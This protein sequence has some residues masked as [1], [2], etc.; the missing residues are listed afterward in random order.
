MVC[1]RKR[2]IVVDTLKFSVDAAL[3]RELGE[4]LIGQ[5]HIALA[6]LIKNSYDADAHTCRVTFS[7]DT[8]EIIDDGHGMSL[9]EFR[10]FWMRIGTTHKLDDRSSRD[11]HRPLTG[12][13]GVG[14]LAVQ[15]LARRMSLET[16]TGTQPATTLW[17]SVDWGTIQ[18]GAELSSV[19][20]EWEHRPDAPSYPN[21]SRHGTRI[22]LSNLSADW[23]DPKK[24][25]ALGG[26]LWTLRSPFRRTRPTGLSHDAQD[27]DVEV[28]SDDVR[29]AQSVFNASQEALFNNWRAR[30]RGELHNGRQGH[31]ATISVEFKTGY[32]EGADAEIFRTS[33]DFPITAD[34]SPLVDEVDFEILV[35]K[36]EG[37]QFGNIKVDEMRRYLSTFGNVSIYDSGFR[38]PYYGADQDWLSIAADQTARLSLSKLLPRSLHL[39]EERYMLDL[40]D[41]RRLY[42][43]VAISTPHERKVAE[44]RAAPNEVLQ[45]QAGRDRLHL[46]DAY[47]QLQQLV[48]YSIDFYA[49]RYRL[50]ASRERDRER[51]V[52]R[53]S[54]KQERAL[55]VL[56]EHQRSIPAPVYQQVRREVS[57]AL[58]ASKA[59]E[60]TQDRR[61]TLLA[62]LAAA[63]MAALALTHELSREQRLLS[64]A[65]KQLRAIA[66][67][68]G[69]PQLAALADE[70]DDSRE[71]LF[72]LSELFSPLSSN[73]DKTA[74]A[75]L[76]VKPVVEQTTGALR[77]LMPGI[78]VD[79]SAIPTD[80]RFPIGAL[81]EWNAVIQNIVTNAWNAMLAASGT[82]LMVDGGSGPRNQ[83]WLRFSD[84][85]AGLGV[86]LSEADRLFE[87]F[88]RALELPDDVKSIAIGGQGL[89]LAIVRMVCAQRRVEVAF[90]EP[91]QGFNT[92]IRLT[93]AG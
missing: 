3:I 20:V 7:G 37:R 64:S 39:G 57:E 55:S 24:L 59:E 44:G 14:R 26:E 89:G 41:P 43:A 11:L 1:H 4:R 47:E 62:P 32:P 22:L 88:E 38:L 28:E 80:L 12:S 49:N 75:R 61:A 93:W 70:L 6:E 77:T 15:F 48:R 36:L 58:V 17:A 33:V 8:I 13:K 9:T 82:K 52:E 56:E 76:R 83:E 74:S 63:G 35:F 86:P 40:P 29:D 84:T 60:D 18:R 51:S 65:V 5:P 45:L 54:E 79:T 16:T 87:P 71:R 34:A 2:G 31:Q 85:G 92:A 27:F 10:D 67:D 81:A 68:S 21:G 19:N 66:K 69:I 73:D 91:P 46:N 53:A 25:R 50:R 72:S 90:V 23:T 78:S 42:G 30:I